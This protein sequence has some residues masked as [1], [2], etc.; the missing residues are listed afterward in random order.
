MLQKGILFYC[1]RFV[2]QLTFCVRVIEQDE[3]NVKFA[4]SSVSGIRKREREGVSDG[5]HGEHE[6]LILMIT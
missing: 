1:F 4:L 3:R 2:F 5:G 6:G